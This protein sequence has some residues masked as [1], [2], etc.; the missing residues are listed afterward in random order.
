MVY[1][2]RYDDMKYCTVFGFELHHC[3]RALVQTD[4]QMPAPDLF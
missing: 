2:P 4:E 1:A 3:N